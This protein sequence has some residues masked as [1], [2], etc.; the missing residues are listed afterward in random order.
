MIPLGVVW[1]HCALY[2][3][4]LVGTHVTQ[5]WHFNLIPLKGVINSSEKK[6]TGKDKK[7]TDFT[8]IKTTTTTTN[9]NEMNETK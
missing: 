9:R 2:K 4:V 3:L 1:P 8:L 5:S 7:L 6:M